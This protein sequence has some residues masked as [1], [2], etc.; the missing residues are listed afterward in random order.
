[1]HHRARAHPKF[2]SIAMLVVLS[3]MFVVNLTVTAVT[4]AVPAIADDLGSPDTTIVWSVTGP[5]LVAAVLGPAFGKAG[6]QAGHRLV[7]IGG[8]ACN[9]LFTVLIA[10]AWDGISFVVLRILAAVGSAAVGPSA[11]AFVNRLYEPEDRAGALGWWSFVSAGSPVIGVFAGGV[12]ID[13]IG[14][15][16]L[17]AAQA[18]LILLGVVLTAILLPETDRS[19]DGRFDMPGAATLAAGVGGILIAVT[20][21]GTNG[22]TGQVIVA[23]VVGVVALV[24][25]AA[26]EV[27]ADAPLLPPHYW[28]LRAF[29]VPAGVLALLF[30]SYMGSFVLVPLMLQDA[31]YG[32]TAAAVSRVVIAR[33]LAFSMM[34]PAAGVLSAK[35]APRTLA[36][37]GGSLVVASMLSLSRIEPGNSLWL[38][39]GALALAGLG[40]GFASP[41]LISV[42]ANAVPDSDL[43]VAGAAQQML[44]TVGIVI[45]IQ[46][47]QALQV[48]MAGETAS[49]ADVVDSYGTTFLIGAVVAA[50][51]AA[52]TLALRVPAVH[53]S[54]HH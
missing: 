53:P 25:F 36:F 21:A 13:A 54:K 7:L 17:F 43:G 18:P 42:V 49:A 29:V 35:F 20:L 45:G 51:G 10:A 4:V 37:L 52:L 39:A 30:A 14:W 6:D 16:W 41:V 3:A 22:V 48:S 1:M 40:M 5:L 15:R 28:R 27:R 9:A 38:T 12:I 46:A 2:P 50:L 11:L 19:G 47:L 26:I 44:Q 23:A 33:P 31:A 32:F 8:L 24:A 34:G